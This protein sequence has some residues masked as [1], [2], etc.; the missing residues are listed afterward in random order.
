[1][2]AA[3]GVIDSIHH[4]GLSL[5][6]SYGLITTLGL[7]LKEFELGLCTSEKCKVELGMPSYLMMG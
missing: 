6:S 3:T 7:S 2:L 5:R 4:D 1:M